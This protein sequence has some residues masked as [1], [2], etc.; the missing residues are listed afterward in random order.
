M[1][2]CPEC[3]RGFSGPAGLKQLHADHK[4]ARSRGG[5]TVWENLVLLCGPCNLTKGN[6]LPHE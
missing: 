3:L 2:T 5:K 4:L 6:K 1:Y